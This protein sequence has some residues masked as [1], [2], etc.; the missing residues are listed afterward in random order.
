MTK[1][2][3]LKISLND[4]RPAVWRRFLVKDSI[5][6]Q[7]LHNVIQIVMGWES[8]HLF[9]FKIGNVVITCEEEGFNPAEASFKKIFD[10]PEFMKMLEKQDLSKDTVILDTDKVNE[11]IKNNEKNKPKNNFSMETKI[12][13]L[14]KSA[15]QKFSYHYDFGDNWKHTINLEK[16]LEKDDSKNYSECIAGERACPPEDCGGVSGYEKLL[17]ILKNKNHK[18]HK[19]MLEWLGGEFDSENFNI[20]K[21]NK[22]LF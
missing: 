21:T 8:Y 17:R 18:E 13:E 5:N 15:G 1:I 12:N 14:I 10:S 6:F 22:T 20:N 2:L 11:I 7:D 4:V 16:I 3:Q 19:E 9:E